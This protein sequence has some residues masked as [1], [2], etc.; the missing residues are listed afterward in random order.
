MLQCNSL[1]TY[2]IF[3]FSQEPASAYIM[4]C[5]WNGAGLVIQ[6]CD[7]MQSPYNLTFSRSDGDTSIA[8]ICRLMSMCCFGGLRSLYR[9][10]QLEWIWRRCLMRPFRISIIQKSWLLPNI[11]SVISL[12]CRVWCVLNDQPWPK[13]GPVAE[14]SCV[15]THI[16]SIWG[17]TWWRHQMET[18][19]ALLTI[20]AGN[21][22]VPGEFPTQRPVTR[23]SDVFFDLRPNKQLRKQWWGWWFGTQ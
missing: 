9:N 6:A 10:L 1:R 13:H 11:P 4:P 12:W 5:V 19:S 16:A 14:M 23:S 2:K 21:S 15:I 17:H 3:I 18:F 7:L 8:L 22:P 20:Y